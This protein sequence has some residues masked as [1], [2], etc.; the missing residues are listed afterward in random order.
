M[1]NIDEFMAR[2]RTE[3]AGRTA[4]QLRELAND[5]DIETIARELHRI[6]GT[7]G[8]YGLVDGS[9]GAAVLLARVREK[10]VDGLAVE[11]NAL[12][13]IFTLSADGGGN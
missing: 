1:D 9:Q 7:C 12:A 11:L 5:L 2:R 8:S 3:L 4:N 10:H 13:E 6:V